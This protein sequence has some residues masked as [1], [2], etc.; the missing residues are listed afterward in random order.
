MRVKLNHFRM[1]IIA[2]LMLLLP[3]QLAAYTK[4]DIVK[5]DGIIYQV[6]SDTDNTLSFVGTEKTK[7]G[8]VNIPA[9]WDD[10]QGIT[11]KVTKVGGN[12]TY[13]CEG[14]TD[15]TLPEGITEIAYGSFGG[16]KLK[17]L[18]IP[19]SVTS[20]SNNAFYRVQELPK[21]TVDHSNAKFC[22][23]GHGALYSKDKVE[24]YAVPTNAD[25]IPNGTYTVDT[26]VKK[27]YHSAFINT[28]NTPGIK[29]IILPPH[30]ELVEADYPSCVQLNTL[31]E[32]EMPAGASGHYKVIG[33][34]LFK[35]N[36]LVQYPRNKQEKN[37]QV[38]DGITEIAPRA[39]DA[40]RNMRNIDLNKVTKLGLT[41]IYSCEN[42]ETVTLP[43]DLQ[44][45]GTAGAIANCPKIKEYKAANDC[46]NF[47]VEDGVV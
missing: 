44:V 19:A 3:K 15:I 26:A 22:D 14:V 23:D 30:L 38:P 5:H 16:A 4:N 1:L 21:V 47:V 28:S 39:I 43:K 35:D 18:K 36:A 29:K 13:K 37:Y 17:T 31:E 7:T 24:L 40:S 8:A 32:Y 6:I 2:F 27:I 12:E 10:G 45:E 11:F 42:L 46:V 34:V 20:I 9:T 33:G 41:S 25:N